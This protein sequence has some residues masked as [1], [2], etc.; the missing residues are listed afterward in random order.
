M[1]WGIAHPCAE[2]YEAKRDRA[3]EQLPAEPSLCSLECVSEDCRSVIQE[4]ATALGL[5]MF[6]LLVRRCSSLLRECLQGKGLLAASTR[7]L[8]AQWG[9]DL[10]SLL[11]SMLLPSAGA[12]G[13]SPSIPSFAQITAGSP[14]RKAPDV[15]RQKCLEE[16]DGLGVCF[17]PATGKLPK[18]GTSES[19]L[20]CSG[21]LLPSVKGITDILSRPPRSV[22]VRRTD[23]SWC[24]L[25]LL[26]VP[27]CV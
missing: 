27:L 14:G 11:F 16:R 1:S 20:W 6:A 26:A 7:L 25:W 23:L 17:L 5:S 4:Q 3:S 18:T 9:S 15:C 12:L 21:T 24:L 2:C 22:C 10:R 19:C 13:F 8:P